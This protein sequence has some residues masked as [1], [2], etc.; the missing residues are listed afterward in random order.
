MENL[1]AFWK[2][3]KKSFGHILSQSVSERATSRD[4]AGY[5]QLWV[6]NLIPQTFLRLLLCM[7]LGVS[8][9]R[10]A[11]LRRKEP[12]PLGSQSSGE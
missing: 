11:G 5:G 3:Q 6:L 1:K 8:C 10:H 7:Q 12:G 2:L 4:I 9:A